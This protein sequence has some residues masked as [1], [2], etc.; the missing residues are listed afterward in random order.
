MPETREK[1]KEETEKWLRKL[2]DEIP[3]INPENDKEKQAL[4]NINAYVEDSS[5]FTEQEDYIRAFEA[6]IWA[7]AVYEMV[8]KFMKE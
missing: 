1:L 3:N 8:F 2:E 6:C 4:E 7:W 5:Y